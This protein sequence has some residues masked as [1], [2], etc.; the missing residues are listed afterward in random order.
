MCLTHL[1]L[2]LSMCTV[3]FQ[4]CQKQWKQFVSQTLWHKPTDNKLQWLL[5][6]PSSNF[7]GGVGGHIIRILINAVF[8]FDV[9]MIKHISNVRKKMLPLCKSCLCQLKNTYSNY[10]FKS[11]IKHELICYKQFSPIRLFFFYVMKYRAYKS[12]CNIFWDW[13]HSLCIC[14]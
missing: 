9:Y 12:T 1:Y 7:V 11:C 8:Q 14:M 2:M 6:F 3:S 4:N 5:Y 13:N 10:L